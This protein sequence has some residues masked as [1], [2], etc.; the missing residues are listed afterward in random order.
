MEGSILGGINSIREN[1]IRRNLSRR[2]DCGMKSSVL[3]KARF[4]HAIAR[5]TPEPIYINSL[6]KI[7]ARIRSSGYIP[8]VLN[9]KNYPVN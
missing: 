8:A 4:G 9:E 1:A 7:S 2:F 3:R 5:Q 6:I